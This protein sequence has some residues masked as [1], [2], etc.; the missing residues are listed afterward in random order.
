M[1]GRLWQSLRALPLVLG[2]GWEGA[3]P[4]EFKRKRKSRD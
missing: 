1:G 2:G 3:S 4:R